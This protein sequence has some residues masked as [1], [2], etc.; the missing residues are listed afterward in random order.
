MIVF[1]LHPSVYPPLHNGTFGPEDFLCL[2]LVSIIAVVAVFLARSDE[3]GKE[4]EVVS[5]SRDD[6][7]GK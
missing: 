6:P 4:D 7:A 1:P 3:K 5:V 2:G